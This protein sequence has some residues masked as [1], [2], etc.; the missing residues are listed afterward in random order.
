LVAVPFSI[1][2]LSLAACSSPAPDIKQAKG[3]G[4]PEAIMTVIANK[5]PL[6]KYLELSGY[7]LTENG[8]GKLTVKFVVVNHSEADIGDLT[9]KVRLVTTAAKPED[10]PITEFEAKVPAL[11][12][13]EIKDVSATA[14]TKLRIYELPDWQFIRAEVEILSPAP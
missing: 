7:R 1:F 11:G 3:S 13:Q 5:H 9:L 14:T 10:P 2:L 12:P 4:A 8:V 6:A